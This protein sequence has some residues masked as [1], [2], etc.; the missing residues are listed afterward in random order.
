CRM[1]PS[2]V[3]QVKAISQTNSGFTHCTA[4]LGFGRRA[5]GQVLSFIAVPLATGPAVFGIFGGRTPSLGIGK[6][7][8]IRGAE[9][10]PR[11]K[12]RVTLFQDPDT[13]A[14]TT[15]RIEHSL[16]P[17]ERRDGKTMAIPREG[18]WAIVRGTASD[19]KAI[20]YRL[21]ATKDEAA[22]FLLKGD[23]NVLFFLDQGR[24]PLVGN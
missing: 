14:P 1:L 23:D 22:A 24:K 10:F 5:N 6:E 11:I 4:A 19:P 13:R 17:K 21:D 7:L 15:Y 3:Q 12:W 16:R 9:R 8:K 2:S 20:V 18:K